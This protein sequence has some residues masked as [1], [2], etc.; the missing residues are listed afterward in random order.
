MSMRSTANKP[1]KPMAKTTTHNERASTVTRI[2]R[3][4]ANELEGRL[5]GV[6]LKD[7]ARGYWAG[8]VSID[9]IKGGIGLM[10]KGQQLAKQRHRLIDG[11]ELYFPSKERD[12]YEALF[13]FL[14]PRTDD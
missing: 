10:K 2:T 7:E 4:L 13:Y 1:R 3:G 5:S 9:P 8:K 6:E 12:C 14:F 11:F